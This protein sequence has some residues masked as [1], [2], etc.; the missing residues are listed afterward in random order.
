MG[1]PLVSTSLVADK[2]WE[3]NGINF[4]FVDEY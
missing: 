2:M 1:F 3:I 4:G